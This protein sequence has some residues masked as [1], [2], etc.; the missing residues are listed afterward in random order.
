MEVAR[1]RA[2]HDECKHVRVGSIRKPNE[3][4]QQSHG[5]PSF[6]CLSNTSDAH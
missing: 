4:R 1:D 6:L 2:R 5:A 3:A